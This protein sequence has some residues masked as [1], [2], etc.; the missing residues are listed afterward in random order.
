[1]TIYRLRRRTT[2]GHMVVTPGQPEPYK[3]VLV[4]EDGRTS[5]RPFHSMQ[6]G[7][8]FLR[9]HSAMVWPPE[10]LEDLLGQRQP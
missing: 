4:Y 3:A 5:E 8:A 9:E 6:E 10:P 1:M 7:E 2:A